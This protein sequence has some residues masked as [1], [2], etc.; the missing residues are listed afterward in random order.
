MRK[1][2]VIGRNKGNASFEAEFEST[3]KDIKQ[4]PV[5]LSILSLRFSYVPYK[6]Y[7][8]YENF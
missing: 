3:C 4:V 5:S 8:A 1:V 2:G 7:G 6:L